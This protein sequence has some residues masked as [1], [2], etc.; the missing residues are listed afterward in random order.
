VAS[1]VVAG[2]AESNLITAGTS[3]PF[4]DTG[5]GWAA[6]G[7]I[8]A[9]DLL[10][11]IADIGST[12]ATWNTHADY[13]ELLDEG[14]ANG[15]TIWYRWAAGGEAAPTFVSSASTRDAS[16]ALRITGAENPATQAPQ[17]ATTSTGSSANPDMPSIT[18]SSSKDYL[19]I[20]FFGTAGEEADDDTWIN[21]GPT[22][23]TF[24]A[25]TNGH[26]KACGVAGTSLGGMIGMAYRQLT[27]GVAEDPGTFNK[28]VTS[29]WRAQ[30]IMVHPASIVNA[31]AE[32]SWAELEVPTANADA[33]VSW[34]EFEVPTANADA[35]ISWAE[36]EVPNAPA[37]DADAEVSFAEFEVPTSA[38]AEVSWTEIEVPTADSRADV[39]WSEFEVPTANADAEVSWAEFEAP[40]ANS[41]AEVAYAALE[42]PSGPTEGRYYGTGSV[43]GAL[44][45]WT[46]VLLSDSAVNQKAGSGMRFKLRLAVEKTGGDTTG[47]MFRARLLLDGIEAARVLHARKAT[48]GR[49]SPFEVDWTDA[50]TEYMMESSEDTEHSASVDVEALSPGG[51]VTATVYVWGM[52]HE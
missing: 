52:G 13:T 5:N 19:F 34:A 23:Y 35:E 8:S 4:L 42:T 14:V 11:V 46:S 47:Y 15:L 50:V 25:A 33:E 12:A 10:I 9:G 26:Q 48:D 36:L 30:T 21:S 51:A 40:T 27:T 32:V 49:E 2:L 44:S 3:H 41:D 20:T 18:P 28:D 17:I 22:N 37:V 6:L 39:S 24:A 16:I 7:T 45:G 31:D 43:T 1:P 38:D 29:A